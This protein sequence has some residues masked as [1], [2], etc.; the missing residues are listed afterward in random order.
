ML[1]LFTFYFIERQPVESLKLILVMP[2]TVSE[3]KSKTLNIILENTTAH[4]I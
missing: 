2:N 3:S 1:D 4:V